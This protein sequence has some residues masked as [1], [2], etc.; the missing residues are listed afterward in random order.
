M[1]H[2]LYKTAYKFFHVTF[3]VGLITTIPRG[4]WKMSDD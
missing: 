1:K 4:K 2:V 3:I